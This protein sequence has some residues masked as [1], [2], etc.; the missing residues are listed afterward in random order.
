MANYVHVH[1]VESNQRQLLL[2]SAKPVPG[3]KEDMALTHGKRYGNRTARTTHCYLLRKKKNLKL[4][5]TY[6]S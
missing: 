2:A 5:I 6:L 1:V 4:D 3:R